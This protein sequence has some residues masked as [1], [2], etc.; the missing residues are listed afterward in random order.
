MKL[1]QKGA[2]AHEKVD[3]FTVGKDREYDLVL[4][5]YD[6]EAS[7]A[8]A[9]MLG[10][11]GLISPEEADQLCSVLKTLKADAEKG[12][13]TIET[14][15]EDMHSKIEHILTQQL[16]DL[17]KK[18]HTA[19]SRNDQV[20]VAMHLYLKHELTEIKS[21]V[22]ALFDLLLELAEKHQ[23]DLIPGYTHLQVAMPSSIGMWLSAYAESLIDDLYFWE[24]AFKISDQNPLGSAAGYG[25]AFPIDRELTTELMAF[26]QLKVNAVAAQ[27]SRGKLE[28]STAMALSSIG[29][30]LAK[31]S[32]DVCLYMGQD[33]DFISFPAELTTGSSIM[34]HKKNPDLFE[35]VRGK[36][37][38]LQA[39]PN[40]LALLTSNLPSGYHRELQLAK[41]PLIDAVQELKACLDILLFSLP[42]MQ[43][44]QNSTDQ[45][46]YDYLFSVDTLNAEVLAGKP[47]RDAYRELGEAIENGSYVPNRTLKHTHLGSIGNLGLETIKNKMKPL[48]G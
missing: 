17:G 35:L 23:N 3:S 7:M 8:H 19:R 21:Q 44:S 45:K 46:K 28:K 42:K 25:S 2:A 12:S 6:C 11:I 16:G 33:F 30:S 20:L 26:Q 36:C 48:R 1:W 13:F 5:Q 10:T 27:M 40:Q 29:S 18:I 41:G 4:A 9:K 15:F 22:I 31:M 39:L 43:V 38:V 24:A 47:F 32:M 14:E 34:P 37:N